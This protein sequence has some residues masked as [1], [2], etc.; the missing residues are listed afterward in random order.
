MSAAPHTSWRDLIVL[1]RGKCNIL[2]T[3]DAIVDLLRCELTAVPDVVHEVVFGLLVSSTTHCRLNGA[4]LLGLIALEFTLLFEKLVTDSPSDGNLLTLMDI[5]VSRIERNSTSFFVSSHSST[6]STAVYS[7]DWL[8][9]QKKELRKRIGW[10]CANDVPG[11][12]AEY[13]GVENCLFESDVHAE[14]R[15]FDESKSVESGPPPLQLNISQSRTE[16]T[17]LARVLRCMIVGLLDPKWE[18][19]HGFSLGLTSILR[20]LLPDSPTGGAHALAPTVLPTFICDDIMCCGVCVLLL[21]RLM[22]F[23]ASAS[24]KGSLSPVKEAAGELLLC[25]LRCRSSPEQC[26]QLWKIIHDMVTLRASHWTSVLGGYIALKHFLMVHAAFLSEQSD[27]DNLVQLLTMGWQEGVTE[28]ITCAALACLVV[29]CDQQASNITNGAQPQ[30]VCAA[31]IGLVRSLGSEMSRLLGGASPSLVLSLSTASACVH[32]LVASIVTTTP[33][34]A[35]PA[36]VVDLCGRL[37]TAQASLLSVLYLFDDKVRG[38]CWQDVVTTL[39][40]LQHTLKAVVNCELDIRADYSALVDQLYSYLGALV[41]SA[42]FATGNPAQELLLEEAAPA[43][44]GSGTAK[45]AAAVRRKRGRAELQLEQELS[46]E[47]TGR[48]LVKRKLGAASGKVGEG[49]DTTAVCERYYADRE[50]WSGVISLWGACL[51]TGL[52]LG[53]SE[54]QAAVGSIVSTLLDVGLTQPCTHSSPAQSFE[55]TF[56]SVMAAFVAHERIA[57]E[58]APAGCMH[59]L[60]EGEQCRVACIVSALVRC[61]GPDQEAATGIAQSSFMSALENAALHAVRASTTVPNSTVGSAP[62]AQN[63]GSTVPAQV[64]AAPVKKRFRF[65]VVPDRAAST[66]GRGNLTAPEGSAATTPHAK[67]GSAL[68]QCEWKLK[69]LYGACAILLEVRGTLGLPCS[70]AV[71]AMTLHIQNRSVRT[72]QDGSVAAADALELV[73]QALTNPSAVGQLPSGHS[74]LL[75]AHVAHHAAAA[76]SASLSILETAGSGF[77]DE[78]DLLQRLPAVLSQAVLFSLTKVSCRFGAPVGLLMNVH[79]VLYCAASYRTGASVEDL[80]Y[81]S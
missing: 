12:A 50:L 15:S 18:I 16:E 34:V 39:T 65:V 51:L 20:N 67:H 6:L 26:R 3:C 13:D 53:Q 35:R 19:R 43:D 41:A 42:C 54:V 80:L 70:E 27:M 17:W 75:V 56:T 40:H 4:T 62:V 37:L 14:P 2:Q 47:D 30:T 64:D 79:C 76:M 58:S 31:C 36:E 61:C 46:T 28:E 1:L 48:S 21:D 78:E 25:A 81:E 71:N 38:L 77:E 74:G 22:D 59:L 68:L 10:E 24:K 8:V 23:S 49:A 11:A 73:R 29:W 60:D 66:A 7:K 57:T 32:G 52:G 5:D 45:G 9:L 72:P 44:S 33:P 63:S 55:R 69:Q